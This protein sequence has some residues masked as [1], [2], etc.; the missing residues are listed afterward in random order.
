LRL[1]PTQAGVAGEY[2]VAAELSL[3]GILSTI[4]LRNSRGIDI[5]ASNSDGSRAVSIQVKT[6][7]NRQ[8]K[9]ILTKKSESFSAD[10]YYYVFVTLNN[11][12]QRPD[13]YVVPSLVVSQYISSSNRDW[14][15]GKKIDGGSRKDS[16]IRNFHDHEG[17]FKEAWHILGL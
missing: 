12:G 15:T 17:R 11:I 3:R 10:D 1:E 8:S 7:Q 4:T 16:G 6:N 9:W 13:F 14:L 2:F 5:I